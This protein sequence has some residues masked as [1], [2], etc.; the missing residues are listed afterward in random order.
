MKII[1]KDGT[2]V[3]RYYHKAT[4]CHLLGNRVRSLWLAQHT[5][6]NP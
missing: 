5:H 6:C 3:I 4:E 1:E 2:V